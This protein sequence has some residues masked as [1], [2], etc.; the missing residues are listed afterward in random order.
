MAKILMTPRAMDYVDV[1]LRKQGRIAPGQI[2]RVSRKEILSEHATTVEVPHRGA[3]SAIGHIAGA[4]TQPI[5]HLAPGMDKHLEF[6]A[7]F[8]DMHADS[9]AAFPR[10]FSAAPEQF[11]EG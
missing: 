9:Q 7:R 11:G 6:L 4:T 3:Q 10:G 5:V 8:G 2:I 1:V